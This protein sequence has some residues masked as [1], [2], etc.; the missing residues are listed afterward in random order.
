[1]SLKNEDPIQNR[2]HQPILEMARVHPRGFIS[3]IRDQILDGIAGQGGG[4]IGTK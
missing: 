2:M 4:L 3:P 1:M